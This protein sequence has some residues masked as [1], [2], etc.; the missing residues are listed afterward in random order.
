MAQ[1]A[2][3]T[4]SPNPSLPWPLLSS[5]DTELLCI[6]C[7][8]QTR[9]HLGAFGG[10]LFSVPGIP[11]PF[12]LY[13]LNLRGS[14]R[15]SVQR[16]PPETELHASSSVCSSQS[17]YHFSDCAGSLLPGSAEPRRPQEAAGPWGSVCLAEPSPRSSQEASQQSSVCD[18]AGRPPP[19]WL[20]LPRGPLLGCS[21]FSC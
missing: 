6:C 19:S 13:L 4:G 8:S 7:P 2:L 1:R 10:G 3:T 11:A 15:H 17:T 9:F 21:L 20:L 5:R 18:P 16:S 14:P 12:F